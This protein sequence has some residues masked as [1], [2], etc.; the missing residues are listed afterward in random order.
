MTMRHLS[1]Q[2]SAL[3]GA[4]PGTGH[5]RFGPGFIEEHELFRI[6]APL[7]HT[8][9]IA[10][11]RHVGTLLLGGPQY[12]FLTSGANAEGPGRGSP[13]SAWSAVSPASRQASDP[14]CD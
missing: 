13:C 5:V 7:L 11:E 12:F 9:Q 2:A 3:Q 8:P 6:E 1:H 14:G 4:A 10:L